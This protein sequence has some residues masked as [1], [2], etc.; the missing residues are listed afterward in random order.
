MGLEIPG[1]NFIKAISVLK[2]LCT[3]NFFLAFGLN[4]YSAETLRCTPDSA[5]CG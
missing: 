5:K 2:S 4:K 1:N 3:I